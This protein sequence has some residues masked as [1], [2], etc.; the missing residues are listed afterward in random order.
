MPKAER[1]ICVDL[2]VED[3]MREKGYAGKLERTMYG[4]QDASNLWQK[5]YSRLIE[6]EEFLPGVANPAMFYCAKWDARLLVHGDD[7]VLLADDEAMAASI[8]SYRKSTR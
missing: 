1:E 8:N 7:F 5:D 6:E 3:P 2:P 4:S